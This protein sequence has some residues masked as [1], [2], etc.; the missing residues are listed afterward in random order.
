MKPDYTVRAADAEDAEVIAFHR[1]AMFFDMGRIKEERMDKLVAASTVY[2]GDALVKKSYF[3]W[4]AEINGK[5]VAS[6]GLVLRT[7]APS[8]EFARVTESAYIHNIYTEPLH[9]RKG[10]ARRLLNAMLDWCRE[11][12]VSSVSLHAAEDGRALYE[13]LGFQPTNEMRLKK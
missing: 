9:R 8:P 10:L 7:M 4:V 12:G 3:G 2:F 13:S 6:G 1:A 5:I 11:R